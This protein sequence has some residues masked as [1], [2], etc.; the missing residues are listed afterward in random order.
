MSQVIVTVRTRYA[1]ALLAGTLMVFTSLDMTSPAVHMVITPD[2]TS[3]MRWHADVEDARERQHQ[4][5]RE[6][7]LELRA[8]DYHCEP[9]SCDRRLAAPLTAYRANALAETTASTSEPIRTGST[10]ADTE[11]RA[12]SVPYVC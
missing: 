2:L 1:L 10:I 7:R 12:Y 3:T 6:R 9:S 11:N 5:Q 4:N 8:S